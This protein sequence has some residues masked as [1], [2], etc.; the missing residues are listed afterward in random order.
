MVALTT[1]RSM[2]T[3]GGL[4]LSN[5]TGSGRGSKD[6]RDERVAI[7]IDP[8]EAIP[9]TQALGDELKIHMVAQSGQASEVEATVAEINLDDL[10][11]FPANSV[12]IKAFTKIKAS[13]LA[14]PLSNELRRYYFKP[15]LADDNWIS[16]ANDLIGKTV[17]HDIE[18]GYI[19]NAADFLPDG[20]L[21]EQV[22]T[23]QTITPDM[24]VGRDSKFINAVAARDIE[25]GH[26]LVENDVL[27][28]GSLVRDVTPFQAITI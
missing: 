11:S 16:N 10:V 8:E 5:A 14:E 17:S 15:G 12:E 25:A 23:F 24:L 22:A 3:Q 21:V 2:T 13:D 27:A 19:F 6:Q 9:L 1:D 7:A 28:A 18:P 26:P 20:S 4:E